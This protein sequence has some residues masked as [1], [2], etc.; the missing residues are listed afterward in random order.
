MQRFASRNCYFYPLCI[1]SFV[2]LCL[3][4]CVWMVHRPWH[5]C[6]NQRVCRSLCYLSPCGAQ[7]SNQG[8]G[9]GRTCFHCWGTSPALDTFSK[10]LPFPCKTFNTI[11]AFLLCLIFLSLFYWALFT[12]AEWLYN[13]NLYKNMYFISS[14]LMFL[15]NIEQHF[16]L[17]WNCLLMNVLSS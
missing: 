10:R 15:L 7:G 6:G 13:Y 14:E 9:V 17:K 5:L 2:C 11:P 1:F 12:E 16:G 8:L 3:C 4:T